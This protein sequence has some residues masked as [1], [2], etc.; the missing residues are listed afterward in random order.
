M[1]TPTITS[2]AA[3]APDC[4]VSSSAST[5]ADSGSFRTAATPAPIPTAT[6][7]VRS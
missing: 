2:G 3:P 7:G 5:I 4:A 1:T 6:A